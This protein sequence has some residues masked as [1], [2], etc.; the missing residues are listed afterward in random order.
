MGREV[1]RMSEIAQKRIYYVAAIGIVAMVLISVIAAAHPFSVQTINTNPQVKTLQVTGEGII[2][3]APDEALLLLA[4][5]TQAATANQAASDNAAIMT[6][7]I[8]ALANLGIGKDA[9][10]TTSYSLTPI[11]NYKPDQTTPPTITGYTAQN[12][13]QVTLTDLGSVGK[14]LDA[15]IAAGVNEVQGV[16]FTL[17]TGAYASFQKQALQLA[18]QDADSKAKSVATSLGVSIVG[19]ISVIPEYMVQPVFNRLTAS[20]SVPTP[21]QAGPLQ[22]TADVQITYQIA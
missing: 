13:I 16:T 22:V 3:A 14:I 1:Q 9:I 4:V 17:S 15:A 5:Q 21:I 20:A 12:A 7:V 18:I 8:A 6:S 19:P 10:Q 11:Y 2:T